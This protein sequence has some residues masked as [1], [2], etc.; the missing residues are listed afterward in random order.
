MAEHGLSCNLEKTNEAPYNAYRVDDCVAKVEV[1][2]V[3][4]LWGAVQSRIMWTTGEIPDKYVANG[5]VVDGQAWQNF[6]Y[7]SSDGE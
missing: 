4:G 6:W 2:V 5:K 1:C 3:V 7:S